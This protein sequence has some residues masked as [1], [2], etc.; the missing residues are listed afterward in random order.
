VPSVRGMMAI[1]VVGIVGVGWRGCWV[2][3][4]ADERVG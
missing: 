2:R 4:V 1:S 3:I